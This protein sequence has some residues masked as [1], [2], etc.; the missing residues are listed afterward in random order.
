[1]SNF[2]L[3]ELYKQT[4]WSVTRPRIYHFRNKSGIEVDFIL[5]DRRIRCIGIEVKKAA[6]VRKDDFKGL[7][8]F[9]DNLKD[10]FMCGIVLYNGNTI[11]PYGNNLFAVPI[12]DL[13]D[14]T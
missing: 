4:E 14:Q 1:M 13:W 12:K 8:W 2:V 3:S 10:Q 11:V 5:E 6:V 7:N 9:K